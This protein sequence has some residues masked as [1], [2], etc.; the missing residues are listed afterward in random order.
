MSMFKMSRRSLG[1][2][3]SFAV[4]LLL[5]TV[6]TLN[7]QVVTNGGF[8]SSSVGDITSTGTKGWVVQVADTA[9][10]KPMYQ[11]VSDTVEQGSRALMV[12]IYNV[13]TGG[14]QWDIQLVADS[15]HVVP[16]IAYNYSIWAKSSKSGATVNFTM[17]NYSY[18]EYGRIGSATL[19]TSWQQYTMHF[20]VNDGQTWIRGPIHL[21]FAANKNDTIWIDNL[22]I[23]DPNAGKKPVIVEAESGQL[24]SHFKVLQD[25][26]NSSITYVTTDTNWTSLTAPGDTSRMITYQVPFADSG[27]YNLFARVRVGPGGFND[28][29]FFYGNGFG[30]KNDTAASDWV[31]INGLASGGFT[32]STA[33]VDGPGSAGNSIWKWV[34]LTKNTYS[35]AKGDTFVVSPDSLTRTFQIGSRE[36]GLDIDK[37]AFGKTSLYFTVH[38]LDSVLAGSPTMQSTDT[39]TVYKGPALA[40]GQ[41][42]FLGCAYDPGQQPTFLNYW[43]QVTPENAGKFGSVAT[44]ADSSTWNWVG[45]DSSYNFAI[46]NHLVFK[47][48]NL[49]WGNQQP[50]WIT[51]AGFDS[52]HQVAAIE[53][54]IR[55]VGRRYPHMNMIDV[56]NEPLP[57]HAPPAYAPALGGAGA[58]GWD[59]VIW[60]FQKAREYMPA[61]TKLLLNDYNILNSSANTTALI[62]IINLLKTRG[63][64]DGIGIQC[65]RFELE[66][67]DT[68][69]IKTNLNQLAAT[70]IPIYISEFDLGNIGDTG[71]PN[72]ATQLQLYQKYFPLLWQ[73]PDVKGITIWG[74]IQ[75]QTWQTTSY[76]VRSDGTARPALLW[77]ANYIK[78][79][80]L[81]VE[82]TA[83][84]LPSSFALDQNYPN[85]FNP[86]TVIRYQL[87]AVGHVT[88][89]VYDVLGRVVETLVD[90][91]QNAGYYNVTFNAN[92][93]AS[94]VYF[95][96][97]RTAHNSS[98]KKMLLLK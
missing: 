43:N 67:T 15:I 18:S 44:S 94:G 33:F 36:D 34:N 89:K 88:L 74:Y 82:Q 75:G 29:S 35:G 97:L 40:A 83:S 5:F 37:I 38:D 10:P 58:T 20:T 12:A 6:E 13:T 65:H 72:D 78:N 3:L 11:I 73:Y 66:N 98:F 95:Y 45:L 62:K 2:L 55:M 76:L 56:V 27:S 42:K 25:S 22:Q 47:D 61:N 96:E 17:G 41:P 8:E 39:G 63:L 49:I 16:G 79:T 70:G 80:T 53:Q 87:S 48:H 50:A 57:G 86:T 30:Q 23:W 84:K 7:A 46:N 51:A 21:D 14:N 93:L 81:G 1:G 91:K 64:I 90:G 26:T 4:M 60:A 92:K 71:T 54:W 19:G 28:D 24:G 77:L 69:L 52:A 31:F 32:D 59:W 9:T 85:P 68:N